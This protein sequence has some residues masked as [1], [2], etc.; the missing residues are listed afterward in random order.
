MFAVQNYVHGAG[1]DQPRYPQPDTGIDYQ[2]GT[3]DICFLIDAWGQVG[4][5]DGGGR[6]K[7]RVHT[8]TC[9]AD[10]RGIPD[11]THYH[12]GAV[13]LRGLDIQNADGF[14]LLQKLRDNRPPQH[15]RAPRH[16][17]YFRLPRTG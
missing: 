9:P 14:S 2:A 4:I 16:Q 10:S 6:M 12:L 3:G 7:D 5:P 15:P 8:L 1:I 17:I 11:I 13:V